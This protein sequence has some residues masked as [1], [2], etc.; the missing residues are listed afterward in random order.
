MRA[1]KKNKRCKTGKSELLQ[2]FLFGLM[3]S[4]P[5]TSISMILRQFFAHL[6]LSGLLACHTFI[7]ISSVVLEWLCSHGKSGLQMLEKV[8]RIR[9]SVYNFFFF[10]Y[11]FHSHSVFGRTHTNI[12]TYLLTRQNNKWKNKRL[13]RKTA[14][15]C[16]C[17]IENQHTETC[18][19]TPQTREDEKKRPERIGF[20]MNERRT[21]SEK[22]AI[23][24]SKWERNKKH[25]SVQTST[26]DSLPVKIISKTETRE[27]NR[28]KFSTKS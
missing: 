20:Q 21:S 15:I 3:N 17:Q 12:H 8:V 5:W 11:L 10:L 26:H 2:Q 9:P 22:K 23:G 27:F 1:T 4:I 19:R 18:T 7:F 14:K 6:S 24:E 13:R 25:F 16:T 28:N